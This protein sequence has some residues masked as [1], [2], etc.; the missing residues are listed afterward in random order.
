MS[1]RIAVYA[2]ER[3]RPRHP[4]ERRRGAVAA[5]TAGDGN[6]MPARCRSVLDLPREGPACPREPL[7]DV[8]GTPQVYRDGCERSR[9]FSVLI[10]EATWRHDPRGAHGP[11]RCRRYCPLLTSILTDS[12]Y[13]RLCILR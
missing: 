4:L 3:R 7:E 11:G 13:N 5:A 12:V 10:V 8:S 6:F 2:R 9:G 1:K